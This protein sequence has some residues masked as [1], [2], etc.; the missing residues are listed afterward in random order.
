MAISGTNYVY[1][2]IQNLLHPECALQGRHQI[3]REK[4][5]NPFYSLLSFEPCHHI[6]AVNSKETVSK[7]KSIGVNEQL[8]SRQEAN[9][10]IYIRV[11][12]GK[13]MK[14]LL[15]KEALCP[16]LHG[17]E[18]KSISFQVLLTAM[19]IL[20]VVEDEYISNESSGINHISRL[21]FE[22]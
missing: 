16:Y 15:H 9:V 17:K 12:T 3:S 7:N 5:G 22:K 20:L 2:N 4:F 18:T 14:R 6:V 13:T 11:S 10:E 8:C 21:R 19:K 1:P